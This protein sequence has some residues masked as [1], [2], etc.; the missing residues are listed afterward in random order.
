MITG[1]ITLHSKHSALSEVEEYPN[2]VWC[3]S[4]LSIQPVAV[5]DYSFSDEFGGV[6]DYQ[7]EP[8]CGCSLDKCIR[9]CS[10]CG[11]LKASLHQVLYNQADPKKKDWKDDWF[12]ND[13]YEAYKDELEGR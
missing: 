5:E 2:G 8:E 6:S 7:A 1:H 10:N 4:C 13:C 11:E 9:G 12:C 3:P